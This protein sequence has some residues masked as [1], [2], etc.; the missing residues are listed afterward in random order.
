MEA[1]RR[2]ADLGWRLTFFFFFP[3]LAAF[4]KQFSKSC[5]NS[6]LMEEITL[7]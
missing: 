5:W 7:G 3:P 2:P 6:R 1:G 4:L